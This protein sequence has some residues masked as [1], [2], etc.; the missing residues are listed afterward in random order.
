M[1]SVVDEGIIYRNPVPHIRAVNAWHPSLVS[2]GAGRWIASFDL[3]QAVEAHD[4]GTV[5]SWS[6]DDGETWSEPRR[7]LGPGEH[8]GSYTLRLSRTQAGRL[9]LAGALHAPREPDQGM[10]NPETFG[11]TPMKLVAMVSDDEGR[12]WTSPVPLK[13]SLPGTEFETCHSVVELSD[14]RL[15]LPTSTWRTWSG[16]APYG[17]KAVLLVSHDYG[18]T[19]PEVITVADDWDRGVTHFE[20]SVVELDSRLVAVTWPL[21]VDDFTTEPTPFAV[22]TDA[23]SFDIGGLTGLFAQTAKLCVLA[24]GSLLCAYRSDRE[25]GLW[26]ARARIEGDRW[27]TDEQVRVW[28]GAAQAGGSSAPAGADDA[29]PADELSDLRFGYPSMVAREDGLVEMLFWRRD[30]DVNVTQRLRLAI[31]QS[32]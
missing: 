11:Y 10:L 30:G 16:D 6:D 14:G 19:W 29:T 18:E 25:P 9:I 31:D 28:A 8:P 12:T 5:L 4:Y 1:I 7:V 26:V 17:M 22:S 20:Q 13:H 2:L 27:V 21:R 15:V 32:T 23:R 24:D 3:G